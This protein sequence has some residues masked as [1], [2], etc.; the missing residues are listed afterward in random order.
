MHTWYMTVDDDG[1]ADDTV[2]RCLNRQDKTSVN[3]LIAQYCL[4]VH[5]EDRYIQLF[6]RSTYIS[7][8]NRSREG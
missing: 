1:D 8:K 3:S 5:N 7:L 6:I 2:Q 4:F